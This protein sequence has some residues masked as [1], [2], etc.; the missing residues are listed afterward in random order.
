MK[1]VVLC[2]GTSTEREVS[3]ISGTG[4][5]KALRQNGHAAILLDVFFGN[6]EAVLMDA[7]PEDY[8]VEAAALYIRSCGTRLK[9]ALENSQR[10][11]FGPN[12]MKLCMMSD[13]VF[14]TLHGANGEDGRIQAVFDL[15]KIRYTGAGYVGSALAMDKGL[16]KIMLADKGIP[17]P[18]GTTMKKGYDSIRIEDAGLHFPVVV[19]V[20]CGG[21]SV[22]VYIV[23]NEEEY[24]KA[25]KEAFLLE[26][27]VVIEEYIKGREFSVGV[28]DGKAL[29]IIEIA[30]RHGFYD[31]KNKYTPGATVDTCPADLTADITQKMQ[32]CAEE[33]CHALGLE[34]YARVDFMMNSYGQMYVL[35]ANTL[36]GMTPTSLM[37]QEAAEAGMDYGAFCERLLAVSLAKYQ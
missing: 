34:G 13:I 22:G 29:P 1:I 8:D 19:K 35:E 32:R 37:P 31:Y 4:V 18:K 16:T 5:C 33:S 11:F 24:E 30:P 28:I 15:M 20:S 36:P 23:H 17:V 26:S 7:F 2:G 10:S 27:E 9:S 6:E 3:I 14:L 21:S 12:V 25:L